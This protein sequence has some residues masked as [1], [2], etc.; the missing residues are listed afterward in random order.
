MEVGPEINQIHC[1]MLGHAPRTDADALS[2]RQIEFRSQMGGPSPKP[3]RFHQAPVWNRAGPSRGAG[4]ELEGLGH[5]NARKT[6]NNV[7]GCILGNKNRRE[8]V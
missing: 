7:I 4:T 5:R 8:K 1:F 3:S 6:I 2:A